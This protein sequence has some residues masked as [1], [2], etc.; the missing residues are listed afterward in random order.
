MGGGGYVYWE[1][2][3]I[4]KESIYLKFFERDYIHLA[5]SYMQ[6]V[7]RANKLKKR[8]DM[9]KNTL[10]KL[11]SKFLSPVL[12]E[13]NELESKVNAA[14]NKLNE[15]ENKINA[16][17]NK[18][19]LTDGIITTN[20]AKFWIPNAPR[21]L[22]Q[23]WILSNQKFPEQDVLKELDKYL[24]KDSVILDI[25]A[26]IGT[27][28]VYWGKITQTKK[29]YAF[30][31]IITTYRIL[32]KN[33]EINGLFTRIKAFN[34]GLGDKKTRA[35]IKNYDL[36]N[37]G[38]TSLEE[39]TNGDIEIHALD[40]IDEINNLARIDFVKI[41]VEGFE[42]YVLEGGKRTLLKHNPII[43]IESF[44]GKDTFDFAYKFLLEL[45][46]GEPIIFP[47]DNY[48]FIKR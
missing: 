46:Y 43:F 34:F 8:R 14:N 6:K 22:L 26:N 10:K 1:T 20:I 13:L 44:S 36:D 21:D 3:A 17:Y 38:S 30:E 45:G 29:V 15:L 28:S 27:H 19:S 7:K 16:V 39:D 35:K 25:G 41:D 23:G 24:D 48:L 32:E 33:I 2:W 40:D 11:R 5:N 9:M 12:L 4:H 18:L 42:K 31:P 37:I 47:Y